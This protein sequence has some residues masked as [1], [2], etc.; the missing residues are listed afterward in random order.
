MESLAEKRAKELFATADKNNDG[1][2]SKS[3]LK[4]SIQDNEA[5]RKELGVADWSSFWAEI[6]A[7]GDGSITLQ[8]LIAHVRKHTAAPQQTETLTKQ[9]ERLFSQQESKKLQEEGIVTLYQFAGG[10]S[11]PSVDPACISVHALL[12]FCNITYKVV[13]C[14]TEALSPSGELPFLRRP[15]DIL[16]AGFDDIAAF[17]RKKSAD[18]NISDFL[19][20]KQRAEL[21]AY[22]SLVR[23]KLRLAALYEVWATEEGFGTLGHPLYSEG[24]YPWPLS[25]VLSAITQ[26]SVRALALN[27]TSLTQRILAA[28]TSLLPSST[29]AATPAA[30][31]NRADATA[32]GGE[33]SSGQARLWSAICKGCDA[34]LSSV[35]A[36][37]VSGKTGHGVLHRG[38]N[39][40]D[41]ITEAML[42]DQARDA[43]HALSMK[44]GSDAFF[45]GD[46]MSELD[47][48]VFGHCA[49]VL[50][51]PV[52]G[53]RLRAA[54]ITFPNLV[55]FVDRVFD[56]FFPDC[57]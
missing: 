53:S 26:H 9:A 21:L 18:M 27:H 42:F 37:A 10:W 35:V 3:E 19:T 57:R 12:R 8:E 13:D 44:L 40:G 48:L 2:L 55:A 28:V 7:N 34:F 5:V 41:V 29:K 22:T 50:K 45:F 1:K 39:T 30:S 25:T 46:R 56:A 54:L 15:N 23:S 20:P 36:S 52:K 43:Y 24:R 49:W 6:D 32:S 33:S 16:L 38:G 31:D 47:A 11:L 4:R 17:A 14:N 51:N